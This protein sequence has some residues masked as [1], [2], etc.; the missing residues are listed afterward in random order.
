M[1]DGVRTGLHLLRLQRVLEPGDRRPRPGFPGPR[2]HSDLAQHGKELQT[3]ARE[4]S[5]SHLARAKPLGVDP[6]LVLVFE[7][8]ALVDADEFRR[9]GLRVLDSSDRQVVIAFADDPELAAFHER[10]D[11][12]Q[13]GVPEG[14]KNEPYAAFFDS[15][16][17]LRPL[18]ASD[19]ITPELQLAI[20]SSPGTTMRLDIECWHPGDR[21]VALEWLADVTTATESLGGRIADRMVN[22]VAGLLL[23]R[24]YL[25]S[26]RVEDLAQLDTIARV[27]VLPFPNLSVP[28]LYG[29]SVDDLPSVGAPSRDAP[30]VGIVDSGVASAHPLL[31]S[32]V[33]TADALGT[34]IDEGEDQHG[35]GTMVAALL[36]HGQVDM[37]LARGLPLVPS[38]R[39]VSARVLDS[40]NNFP[41][42]AL[43]ERD[44]A[45][46]IEWCADQ[47]AKVINLSIGDSR[48]PFRPQRQSIAAALV[49]E[50]ARRRDLVVVIS[51]GY[52]SPADYLSVVEERSAVT[53]PVALLAD[54]NAGILDPGPAMLALTVG[55]VTMAAASSGLSSRETVTRVPMGRPGWPSPFSR[56]GHGQ[57]GAVKPE[58]VHLAG[59]LGIETG[60]LVNNDAELGVI[61]AGIGG[62]RLLAH[63]I[64]TSYAAPLVS[65]IAAAVTGRFPSFGANAIRSLVLISAKDTNFGTE[66]VVEKE[67]DRSDAVRRLVGFGRP[68]IARATE[69]TSH[70]VVLVAEDA[71]PIN[72][73]HIYELPMPSSFYQSGGTRG[74]DVSLA[75]DPPTRASRLDYMASRM[76]FHL[77]RGMPLDEVT[78]VFA[79]IEG[80]DE[81]VLDE[82]A[83]EVDD[84]GPEQV[85]PSGPPTISS[86]GSRV[87]KLGPAVTVRSRGANQLGRCTFSQRLNADR[88]DPAFLVVRNVN[89]WDDDAQTQG[90]ALAVAMWRTD[91][92]GE[93]FAELEAK[94]E[95][96]IE[97]PIEIELEA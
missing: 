43:W 54:E 78:Q 6:R 12:L 7:L 80:D 18:E 33:L 25:N 46:A 51:A 77:V 68:S 26:D 52:I 92:H 15:I 19:R 71:I 23:A 95:S 10:L 44:L 86:L 94:L 13:A 5:L 3:R 8:G 89:R 65:R 40:H 27:D 47:G 9:A 53:Y 34:G 81:I 85:A 76:E 29:S 75:F 1:S 84:D 93:L 83:T 90:Y 39:I 56:R 50:I 72:G 96:V 70:R 30:I 17:D 74:I 24:A 67:S 11:A 73:V 48:S 91:D 21:D 69:S 57:G 32:A 87:V 66:L 38:C 42:D 16:D 31:A 62:T 37:A 64:G 82:N 88:H 22:D 20:D 4:I 97:V 28:Q 49:D 58:L 59:T 63:D 60:R 45:E 41:D 2:R 61:S 14:R 36:L 55:G 35:H 79:S